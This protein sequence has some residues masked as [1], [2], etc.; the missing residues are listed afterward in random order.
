MQF[1]VIVVTDPPTHPQ[2]GP[3]TK[4]YVPQLV[5]SAIITDNSRCLFALTAV[6]VVLFFNMKTKLLMS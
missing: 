5:R 1:R 2:T 4:H 3:I 6:T